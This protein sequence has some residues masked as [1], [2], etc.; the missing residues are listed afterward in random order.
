M[1]MGSLQILCGLSY[2]QN[3]I[4]ESF[5]PYTK[6]F[7]ILKSLLVENSYFVMWLFDVLIF[8]L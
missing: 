1:D 8:K 2:V 6:Q 7:E 3:R 4:S 5:S